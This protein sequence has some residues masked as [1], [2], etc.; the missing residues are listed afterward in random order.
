MKA[1]KARRRVLRTILLVGEGDAEV[2]FIN[3]LKQVC[4]GGTFRLHFWK[5]P[6]LGHQSLNSCWRC[7]SQHKGLHAGLPFGGHP[8]FACVNKLINAL[9]LKR[10]A[11]QAQ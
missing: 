1:N 4:T 3:H 7:S 6:D 9:S 11:Q 8:A 2:A 5:E 10:D